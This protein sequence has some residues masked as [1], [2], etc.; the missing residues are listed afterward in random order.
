MG[1]ETSTKTLN[2]RFDELFKLFG[3]RNRMYMPD[4]GDRF[5][6]LNGSLRHLIKLLRRGVTDKEGLGRALA[7]IFARTS[8]FARSFGNI[9]IV[10]SLTTK[11]PHSGGCSWC[12]A[13]PCVC[14]AARTNDITY[15][16]PS[17]VQLTWG[18]NDW[19]KHLEKLYGKNNRERGLL[20]AVMRLAEEIGEVGDTALIDIN[21]PK[22]SSDEL[23]NIIARE[24]ADTFAWIFTICSLLGIDLDTEL[25]ENY[26]G[27]HKRCNSRPCTCGP[28]HRYRNETANTIPM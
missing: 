12:S 3:Q 11:Y 21:N 26:S 1:R 23:S 7:S 25:Q 16:P 6:F 14:P 2:E 17:V 10:E 22:I 27:K 13:I 15:A 24:F 8:N 4:R 19:C 9:P 5:I 20:A 18:V 28:F